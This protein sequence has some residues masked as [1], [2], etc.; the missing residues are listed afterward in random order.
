MSPKVCA[1]DVSPTRVRGVKL[2]RMRMVQDPRGS[3]SAGEFER[4]VPF[5]AQRY[6]LVFDVPSDGVRGAHAHRL[7]HQFLV[8]I[9]G[10]CTVLVDDGTEREEIRLESPAVGVHLPPMI[11]ATQHQYSTD[12][13]LLVFASHCYDPADYIREYDEFLQEVRAGAAAPARAADAELHE[14]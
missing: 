2:H 7:C 11:W 3:L 8:C 10:A 14:K 6:F 5:P 9:K 4:E 12:A 13:I 1:E